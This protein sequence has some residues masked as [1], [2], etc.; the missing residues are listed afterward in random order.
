METPY[1]LPALCCL[2]LP[3]VHSD[4]STRRIP[5]WLTLSGCLAG[6]SLALWQQG[7]FGLGVSALAMLAA[8]AIAFAFWLCGWL[9]AGDVKLLA[10]VGACAGLALLPQILLL[11]ALSGMALALVVMI[12]SGQTRYTLARLYYLLGLSLIVKKSVSL[13]PAP[14]NPARLPYA[15]A[16]ATGSVGA[17]LQAG[18]G[19]PA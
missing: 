4:L 16:I 11:T 2:L 6:L 8:F 5:N 12:W 15:L 10:A 14:A 13:P 7:W 3:A 17:V 9:G 19:L 18:V 1:L